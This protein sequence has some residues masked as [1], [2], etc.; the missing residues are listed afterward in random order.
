MGLPPIS[1]Q[2]FLCALD[3]GGEPLVRGLIGVRLRLGVRLVE[4]K[5]AGKAQDEECECGFH[6]VVLFEN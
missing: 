5:E 3:L 1:T 6:G 4:E 2:T